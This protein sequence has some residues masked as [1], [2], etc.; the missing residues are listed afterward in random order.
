MAAILFHIGL[1]AYAVAAVGH[2]VGLLKQRPNASPSDETVSLGHRIGDRG[3]AIG[4]AFHGAS[5]LLRGIELVQGGAFRFA[6]GLSFLAFLT[7][8]IYLTVGRALRIPIF[9]ASLAPLVVALLMP[10]HAIP[11][12]TA[13]P[14]TW[15]GWIRPVHIAVALGGLALFGLGCLISSFYLLL[16]RELKARR[17]GTM[18]HRL[19]SLAHLDTITLRVITWGF[20]L[21]SLTI[22]TGALFPQGGGSFG[23]RLV[24]KEAMG[25]LAWG[26]TAAILVLRQTLGW[27]GKRV[28][29]ATMMGFLCLA[30]AFMGVF[31]GR[32]V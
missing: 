21:L 15:L 8:G 20:V 32:T 3:L 7:V 4:F 1:A 16:Q 13:P 2:V 6:E 29:L 17:P 23:L 12:P 24:T 18:F 19:P 14:P 10:A 28:A 5:V 31:V 22:L 26:L 27:R 25:L 30:V 11:D 9:G